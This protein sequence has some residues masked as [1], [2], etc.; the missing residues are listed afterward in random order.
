MANIP[1]LRAVLMHDAT[2][3]Y[4]THIPQTP[5][6]PYCYCKRVTN[7]IRAVKTHVLPCPWYTVLNHSVYN[8]VQTTV[9]EAT[10]AKREH[11]V[12]KAH[13]ADSII[14]I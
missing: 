7:A 9:S 2:C 1:W 5:E 13:L 10:N 14:L 4:I 8:N 3:L 12:F 11:T 6:V